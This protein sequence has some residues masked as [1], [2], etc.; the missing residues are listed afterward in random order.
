MLDAGVKLGNGEVKLEAG[1]K[2]C[3]WAGRWSALGCKGSEGGVGVWFPSEN[4][5]CAGG[6]D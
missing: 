5:V 6:A 3:C 1:V 2:L 4:G